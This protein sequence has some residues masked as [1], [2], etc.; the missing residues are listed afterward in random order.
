MI[1][2]DRNALDFMDEDLLC[3]LIWPLQLFSFLCAFGLII[4]IATRFKRINTGQSQKEHLNVSLLIV[5]LVAFLLTLPTLIIDQAVQ[6]T[7][8]TELIS[9]TKKDRN[10]FCFYNSSVIGTMV[11][12]VCLQLPSL[13]TIIYNIDAYRKGVHSLKA[14]SSEVLGSMRHQP[15]THSLTQ[16][17]TVVQYIE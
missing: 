14:S 5:P 17:L 10:E 3:S 4:L 7:N 13:L 2:D 15:L 8:I 12:Y 1:Y 9:N 16:L 11:N 6:S